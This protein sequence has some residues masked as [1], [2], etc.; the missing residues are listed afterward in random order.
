MGHYYVVVM[1][2]WAL[3]AAVA[4]HEVAP[5]ISAQLGWSCA[6]ARRVVLVAVLL[7]V[8]LP[9]LSWVVC[10]KQQFAAEKAAGGNPFLESPAV[11]RR[12]AELTSPGDLVYVAGSEPQILYYANRMSPTRFVIA[13]PLMIATPVAA[14]YQQ[15][16]MRDLERRPP[17]VIVLSPTPFSWMPQPGSPLEFLNYLEKLLA[18]HYD[19]VGG[20]VGDRLTGSWREPLTPRD[21]ARSSLVVFRRKGA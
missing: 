17:R 10:T 7:L 16:A 2:F 8:C 4:I 5:L 12:V 3:L 1:P 11:A 9:D 18:E 15:E 14:T 6:W 20:W 21:Q 19:P 13:Y